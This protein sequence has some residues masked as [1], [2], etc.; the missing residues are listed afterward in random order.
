MDDGTLFGIAIVAI[1]VTVGFFGV[2][3]PLYGNFNYQEK[4]GTI[5]R[6]ELL[7]GHIGSTM[8]KTVV[9]F[10]DGST[11]VVDVDS[12]G[13]ANQYVNKTVVMKYNTYTIKSIVEII[14]S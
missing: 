12:F 5:V 14:K 8:D 13:L 10:S 9:A 4:T 3:L 11:V 2:A 7:A 6:V 1:I